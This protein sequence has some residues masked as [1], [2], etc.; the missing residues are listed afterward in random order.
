M[1]KC[2]RFLVDYDHQVRR[3]VTIAYK[4]GMEMSV[5][6]AHARAALAAGKAE[7]VAEKAR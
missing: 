1:S 4:A 7:V 3:G 5:P 2:V 6:D